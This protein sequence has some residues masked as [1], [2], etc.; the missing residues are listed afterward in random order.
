MHE[1]PSRADSLADK[2][3]GLVEVLRNILRYGIG[4]FQ[5]Q[6][7]EVGGVA[8]LQLASSNQNMSDVHEFEGRAIP[9]SF[10]VSDE[11]SLNNAAVVAEEGLRCVDGGNLLEARATDP[12]PADHNRFKFILT[13]TEC[14]TIS[15]GLGAAVQ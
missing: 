11:Q 13:T 5:L 1:H 3:G 14:G 4:H 10:I 12:L 7:N 6:V 8:D 15:S 9:S 2:L